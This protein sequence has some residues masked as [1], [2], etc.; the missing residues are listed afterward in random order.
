MNSEKIL[1][2]RNVE[3]L[4]TGSASFSF[5]VSAMLIF[6][7]GS[8]HNNQFPFHPLHINSLG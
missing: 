8:F 4:S 7:W 1:Q 3:M 5:S 2:I 6:L